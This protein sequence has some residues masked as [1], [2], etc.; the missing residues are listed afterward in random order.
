MKKRIR[1]STFAAAIFGVLLAFALGPCAAA[2]SQDGMP[3]RIVV[4]SMRPPFAF[5]TPTGVLAG[6]DVAIAGA[7]CR[8]MRRPCLITARPLSRALK[9]LETGAIDMVVAGLVPT[10]DLLKRFDFTERYY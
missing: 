4:E 5:R 1:L 2:G 8:E 6:F 7:L 9:E 3:L 10:P